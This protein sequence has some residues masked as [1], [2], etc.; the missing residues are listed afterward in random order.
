MKCDC[1]WMAWQHGGSLIVKRWWNH[2][3]WVQG[4]NLYRM[5]NCHD[6]RAY[7]YKCWNWSPMGLGHKGPSL[8]PCPDRAQSPQLEGGGLRHNANKIGHAN[9]SSPSKR[10]TPKIRGSAPVR[11]AAMGCTIA[12]H[13]PLLPRRRRRL[14]TRMTVSPRYD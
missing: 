9:Q 10:W 4:T 8:T 3:T 1:A 11:H 6:S 7:S 2:Y 14:R 12:G 5:Y 13:I